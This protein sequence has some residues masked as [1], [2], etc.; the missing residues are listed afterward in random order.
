MINARHLCKARFLDEDSWYNSSWWEETDY[1]RAVIVD[2]SLPVPRWQRAAASIDL[3]SSR[4]CVHS[5]F[6]GRRHRT[7]TSEINEAIAKLSRRE[8]ITGTGAVGVWKTF[9]IP[10][11]FLRNARVII[12]RN[13]AS[14]GGRKFWRIAATYGAS[15]PEIFQWPNELEQ[16]AT[17]LEREFIGRWY[18]ARWL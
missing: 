8:T 1:R 13:D 7:D 5:S 2:P 6:A 4:S 14:P 15:L 9:F 17:R 10:A 16:P 3:A 12:M 18:D 11:N